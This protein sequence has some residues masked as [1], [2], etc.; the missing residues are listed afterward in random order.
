MNTSL[1]LFEQVFAGDAA[2]TGPP[3][4][5]ATLRDSGIESVLAHTP[6]TYKSRFI[7]IIKGFAKGHTFTVEEVRD[8]AGELPREIHCNAIGA[9]MRHA[10][11]KNLI[12]L[13]NETRTSERSSR[14]VHFALRPEP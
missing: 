14:L 3:L 8:R 6:E 11:K 5:G 4:T 1:P 13:M 9:L 2:P 12:V 7:E 10:A